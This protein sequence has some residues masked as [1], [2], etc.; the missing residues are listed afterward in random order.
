[1]RRTSLFL[2]AQI[3]LLANSASSQRVWLPA[4]A[5]RNISIDVVKGFYKSNPY[6]SIDF[7]SFTVDL[8]ARF[9]LNDKVAL[10]TAIPFS[11]VS[12]TTT[13][14]STSESTSESAFGNP[15]LGIETVAGPDVVIE[16]GVRAGI[17][18][19]EKPVAASLGILNDFDRFEAWLPKT[20]SGRM[21]AH[22]GRIPDQGPF[23]TGLLGATYA[24]P[25]GSD[26][27]DNTLYG[28]YGVRAGFMGS[29][30]LGSV[31]ITGRANISEGDMSFSE[32]TM[33]QLGFNLEGT[34]GKFRPSGSIRTYLDKAPRESLKA[35]LTLGA[36]IVF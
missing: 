2:L 35:I 34:R 6:S 17:A 7:A 23:V 21:I 9:P 36:S 31:T 22:I 3:A 4:V 8:Q 5:T 20:T 30:L 27:G 18:S 33:H 26:G 1:M 12:E 24:V 28:S 11:R 25:G 32:R 14:G 15:W 29:A 16:F 13:F 19:D 10:T